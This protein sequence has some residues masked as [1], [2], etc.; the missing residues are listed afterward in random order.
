M[1]EELEVKNF[2]LIT[3][4]RVEFGR[5]FTVLSG[6][7]G[8]GKSLLIGSLAFLTGGKA[9][10]DQIR[11]GCTEAVVSAVFSFDKG[12]QQ[13]A[14][15]WLADRGIEAEEE[16][17]II[18]RVIRESG[19]SSAWI[20]G[21]PVTRADLEEFSPFLVDIHGQHAQQS[22]MKVG[23]HRRYL[24]A[25]AGVQDDVADFGTL[26]ESLVSKRKAL[27]SL[28]DSEQERQQKIDMLTFALGEI[29]AAHLRV[30]EED[31]LEGEQ[32]RLSSF[33]KL[34]EL[35]S[36]VNTSLE[37][38]ALPALKR[39]LGS[40]QKAAGSDKA[41]SSVADRLSSAFYEIDDVA[42]EARRYADD[43][44]F[45]T[46]RLEAVQERLDVI[47]KLK[48]K[49]ARGEPTVEAVLAYA[50]KAAGEL[51]KLKSSDEDKSTL[52][53]D[54]SRLE[55][56]VYE[57]AR[58]LSEKRKAAAGEMSHQVEAVLGALGMKGAAFRVALREK[59]GD[60]TWQKCGPYGMDDVEFMIAANAGSPL[61]PLSKIASGGEISRVML[62]LKTIL[63]AG[64]LAGTLVFDEIDSGIGGE[65]AVSVGQ[66]MKN[67]AK[68]K[69]V[70]CITHL[71]SIAVYAGCQIKIQKAQSEG[72]TSS[73]L[74][75]VTGEERVKEIAR[76]LSGDST[77]TQSLDHARAM[78][79]EFSGQQGCVQGQL[80]G[81]LPF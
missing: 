18:R 32:A 47:R 15:S 68:T 2:A 54:V 3:S 48:R 28:C 59:P 64:D 66:H 33:E 13:A 30:D 9:G 58:V 38:A 45:D 27:A 25:F 11:P 8:A 26:Y 14:L 6:E 19:K 55:A 70:L 4:S 67:L 7:T 74:H 31:E 44:V 51:E 61:M 60:E 36:E 42:H 12:T 53:A 22:L 17:V 71:A 63:S 20:S 35:I 69:Q 77:S 79:E 16:R 37:E 52:E 50:D 39:S 43:L 10:V 24:D 1:I 72:E 81:E 78:L 34:S 5:G 62:A 56:Q 65:V 41:L 21:T 76:M 75:E 40:A 73:T 49:Y 80:A 46:A 57:A 29:E 23:E